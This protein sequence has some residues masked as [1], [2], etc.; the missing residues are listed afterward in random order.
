MILGMVALI[1]ASVLFA[2]YRHQLH[3]SYTDKESNYIAE[4]DLRIS[5]LEKQSKEKFDA[6][7]FDDLKSK[8]EALRLA[9]GL[10]STR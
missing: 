6:A 8:V 1:C 5:A 10:R 3:A 9:Q 7:A 2:Q 4:L